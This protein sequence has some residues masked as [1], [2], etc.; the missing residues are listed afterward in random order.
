MLKVGYV[1]VGMYLEFTIDMPEEERKRG[2]VDGHGRILTSQI[3]QVT[4]L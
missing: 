3:Q 1:G 4:E 2:V